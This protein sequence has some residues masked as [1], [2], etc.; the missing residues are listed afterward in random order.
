MSEEEP[1]NKEE[2]RVHSNFKDRA[3][4]ELCDAVE[5]V[6]ISWMLRLLIKADEKKVPS[7]SLI[8]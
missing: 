6:D 5:N 7:D 1:K 3:F 8:I 2:L 4:L